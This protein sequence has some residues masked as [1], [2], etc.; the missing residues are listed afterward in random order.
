MCLDYHIKRCEGP[1]EGLVSSIE[2]NEMITQIKHFL[3]G[4][5]KNIKKYLQVQMDIASK[6]KDYEDAAR[7]RDQLNAVNNFPLGKRSLFRI[8]KIGILYLFHLKT[9]MALEL[10]CEFVMGT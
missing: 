10:L 1:C 4:H 7:Y 6:D 5:S 2:Y 8:L 9:L 3:K